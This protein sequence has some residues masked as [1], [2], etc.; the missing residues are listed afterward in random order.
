MTRSTMQARSE[1]ASV[2]PTTQ[3]R[4]I[5]TL[6]GPAGAGKSTVA[7]L[8]AARLG[9]LYLDTGALYRAVAWKVR[10]AGVDSSD[11]AA[12][13][14][15]LPETKVALE[16]RPER[17]LVSVDG[18][19]VT[20]E[21]RTPEISRLASLVSA[22]PAVREWLLPVQRDIGAAGGIVAEGR[23]LGTRIFPQA[24]AKFFLDA[25]V[26]T[27]A[28]RRHHD[29]AGVGQA[30]RLEETRREI[31][32]RDRQDRTRELAP[33]VPAPDA[34]R[35][36]SSALTVEQVVDRLLDVIATKL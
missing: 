13:A 8:L 12:V 15:L 22:I 10:E 2:A 25:D 7:K 16:Y 31:E 1:A 18:R 23:D 17:P 26:A 19:D 33:L 21:I 3:Q 14:A 11:A 35:I 27:R 34:V 24:Q 30:S 6:D 36:D 28:A 4:L 20:E 32:A 5:V 29:L 9:Y